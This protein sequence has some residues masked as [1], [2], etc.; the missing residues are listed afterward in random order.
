MSDEGTT[1]RLNARLPAGSRE[2]LAQL[3]RMLRQ[4][5]G[6]D[7]SIAEAV[8]FAIRCGVEDAETSVARIV[9]S[10]IDDLDARR[11]PSA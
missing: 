6:R 1:Y 4:V 8:A 7:W 9:A 11:R 2:D 5:T 3:R 10:R